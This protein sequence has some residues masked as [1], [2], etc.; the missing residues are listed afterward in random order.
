MSNSWYPRYYG[1]YMRDTAHLTLTE[2]GV[3]TI[4]LDHYYAT[5]AALPDDPKALIRVCRAYE[6]AER[7]AVLRI[8][9][10]FFPV[11]G[12]GR[13]HNKRAD[14]EM[15]RMADHSKRLSEAGRR[16]GKASVQAR[17]KPGLK[18]GHKPGS[19]KS[20][21]TTTEEQ[22]EAQSDGTLAPVA[23][24]RDVLMDALGG[25]EGNIMELNRATWG[26]VARALKQIREV[27]PDVTPDEIRRR[28]ANYETH[29]EGAALTSTALSNHWAKCGAERPPIKAR[30]VE[31][32]SWTD[33]GT[34]GL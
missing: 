10:D 24:P 31:L 4:L 25:C 21:S 26:K 7:Q 16:G 18:R 19:S 34:G 11:N 3:Y 1:D 15:I 27:S 17:L 13:R 9:A 32:R 8:A 2:H 12:D 14:R 20:I 6:E 23:R 29:F 28:A 5:G 22:P 33:L 30:K